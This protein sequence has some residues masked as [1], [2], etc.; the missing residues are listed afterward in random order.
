MGGKEVA[1]LLRKGLSMFAVGAIVMDV[2]A[3][4]WIILVIY[5]LV[6][7]SLVWGLVLGSP[8]VLMVLWFLF[9]LVKTLLIKTD[10]EE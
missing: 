9:L 2:V 6:S 10:E 4:G 3:L 7:G 8:L 1:D 5:L